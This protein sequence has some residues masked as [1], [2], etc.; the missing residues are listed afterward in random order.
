MSRRAPALV[1]AAVLALLAGAAR[2]AAAQEPPPP[3]LPRQELREVGVEV[4][5]G[6]TPFAPGSPAEGVLVA[7]VSPGEAPDAAQSRAVRT[8]PAGHAVLGVPA[9]GAV[10]VFW[11]AG[12]APRAVWLRRALT[13]PVVLSPA[14]ALDVVVRD[15]T[16]A[17]ARGERVELGVALPVAGAAGS[18]PTTHT[19]ALAATT[20]D[21]GRARFPGLPDAPLDVRVTSSRWVAPESGPVRAGGAPCVV[22][23]RRG[24]AVAG[25]ARRI[26]GGGAAA[27]A[28]L[29]LA[30]REATVAPDGAFSFDGLPPGIA[31]L[32]VLDRDL[33]LRTPL[34]LSLAQGDRRTALEVDLVAAAVLAGR[35]YAGDGSPAPRA[36]LVLRWPPD[37]WHPA[38]LVREFPAAV[39]PESD[40]RFRLDGLP[41]ADGVTCE[42]RAPGHAPRVV[43]GLALRPGEQGP[44][45]DVVLARGARLGG[46]IE[47]A[48][49]LAAPG[50][51][52]EVRS[53]GDADTRA[54]ADAAVTAAD[55]TFVLVGV[56]GRPVRLRLVPPAGTP[57][58]TLTAGPFEPGA[59][60]AVDVGVLRLPAGH[61]LRG[62]V[63]GAPAG[64]VARVTDAEGASAEAPLEDGAFAFD[65]LATGDAELVVTAPG[66]A[67]G[68]RARV[69]L[70]AG[71]PLALAWTA[72]VRLSV[73]LTGPGA[74]PVRRATLRAEPVDGAEGEAAVERESSDVDG[75]HALDLAAGLWRVTARAADLVGSA[76][77]AVAQPATRVEL[78]LRHGESVRG[79]VASRLRGTV[80]EG[81]R[82]HVERLDGAASAASVVTDARG[83][84]VVPGVAPGVVRIVVEAAG[85][86]RHVSRPLTVQRA[87]TLDVGLVELRPGTTLTG[88]AT[89]ESGTPARGLRIVVRPDDGGEHAAETDLHGRFAVPFLPRGGA[90]VE[91]GGRAQRIWISGDD[92]EQELLLDFAAGTV[93]HGVVSAGGRPLPYARVDAWTLVGRRLAVG[94]WCDAYGRYRL[95]A[96]PPGA[97]RIGVL[98]AGAADARTFDVELPRAA[99][100]LVDLDLPDGAVLGRVVD[101]DRNGVGGARVRVFE[102]G[103]GVERVVAEAATEPGGAFRIAGLDAGTHRIEAS[104]PG[105]SRATS[106]GVRLRRGE[107]LLGVEIELPADTGVVAEIVDERGQPLAGAWLAAEPDDAAAAPVRIRARSGPDGRVRL[108]GLAPG[109]W[110]LEAGA[111]GRGSVDA[112][113][114]FLRVGLEEAGRIVLEPA[115]ALEVHVFRGGFLPAPGVDVE[116]RDLTGRDP[117]GPEPE[118]G[119]L[120]PPDLLRRSG[121]DGRLLVSD[122]APGVYRLRVAGADGDAGRLVRVRAGEVSSEYLWSR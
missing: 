98:P 9:S 18:A 122:L 64:A 62:R 100:H 58:R 115:G 81:A 66:S 97:T 14:L 86:A 36:D 53:E 29:R 10:V 34:R 23:L 56:P 11:S 26:P 65:G 78:E 104:A 52:V 69:R 85:H 31:E 120:D 91:A 103:H 67:A 118:R 38:G 101:R 112:G 42:V 113:R 12:D 93:V 37:A 102:T 59:D 28:R 92:R 76:D 110:R 4:R 19:Y 94:A 32:E 60:A 95:P 121:P 96:L 48:D 73:Q 49:G 74:A 8:D 46:R 116:L 77:V 39:V 47:G 43:E 61:A 79:E 55:G 15:P 27:G 72:G 1:C 45:L 88:I 25:S 17:P 71:W 41:P 82:V 30:G 3:A 44:P 80:L 35:V 40:G 117:R 21:E 20:D 57:W 70:P 7:A 16:G 5:R 51:R 33:L 89:A 108:G 84:F 106:E 13:G 107:T 119:L 114:F 54:P 6:M 68:V 83:G 50:V 90:L 87:S 99:D 22:E 2:R 75:V 111:A 63:A 105:H 24:A 109:S